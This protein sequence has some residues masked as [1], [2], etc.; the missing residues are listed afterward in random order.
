SCHPAPLFTDFS[1]RNNG[2]LPDPVIDDLGRALI[3]LDPNDNYKFKVPSLR[4]LTYSGLYMHD[5]R[6]RNLSQ[7][8]E[9]YEK[10]IIP[11][12][13]LDPLLAEGIKLSLEEKN[14]LINFLK[15][16]DDEN[17]VKDPRFKE[18]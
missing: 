13:S 9:H 3:T 6:F 16:L 1:F 11:S 15:T 10:E 2:L 14:H 17:F 8:L 5:G 7:V 18:P 4:N 12:Q